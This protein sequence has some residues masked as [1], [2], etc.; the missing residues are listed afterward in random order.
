MFRTIRDP[1]FH[2]SIRGSTRYVSQDGPIEGDWLLP[3]YVG[4]LFRNRPTH[5]Q[6]REHQ[7]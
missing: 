1:E 6:D 7:Q 2:G 3:A 4:S 5:Q